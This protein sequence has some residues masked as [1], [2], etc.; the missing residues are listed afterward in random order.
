M[1]A[2]ATASTP[3][4]PTQEGGLGRHV[5]YTRRVFG[6][7][8]GVAVLAIVLTAVLIAGRAQTGAGFERIVRCRA[9]HLFTTTLV[10]GVSLKAVRLW[11]VRFERCPVGRHWTT[12]TP[13]DVSTLTPEEIEAARSRHDIRIP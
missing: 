4:R 13:V 2:V 6:L 3:G 1:L 12:V 8:V 11:N 7:A 9:G 10:P 5:T